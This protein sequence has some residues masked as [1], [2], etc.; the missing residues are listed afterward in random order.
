MKLKIFWSMLMAVA[1]T[2]GIIAVDPGVSSSIAFAQ[3]PKPTPPKSKAPTASASSSFSS[4]ERGLGMEYQISV[5]SNPETDRHVPASA[6]N[7]TNRQTLVVWHRHDSSFYYIEGRLLDARGKPIGSLP[8]T[9]VSGGTPV[10][11]PAVAYNATFNQYLVVWMRNTL[12]DGKTYA[13]WGKVLS[14]SLTEVRPEYAIFNPTT[15]YSAW[16]PRVA[17]NS[18]KNEYMVVWNAFNTT[19]WPTMFPESIAQASL[20]ENG[21]VIPNPMTIIYNTPDKLIYPQQVDIVFANNGGTN[22]WGQYMWV[23]KQVKLGT[24]DYDIWAANI[25]AGLGGYIQGL[26]PWKVD[27]SSSDQSN[28]RIATNG[29]NDF[30]V[31]WQERSPNSPN[32]WDI[33]GRE[34]NHIGTFFGDLHIIAGYGSTDETNPFVVGWAGTTPRY[35]VGYQRQS[36]TGQGIWLA[37][38]NNGANAWHI[39]PYI[40]WMDYFAAADYGF[41]SNT[42]PTGVVA[43]PHVQMAYEGVSNTPGDHTHIYSRN[44]TPF[45]LYLPLILK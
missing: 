16:S 41:W 27:D 4:Q 43:G 10:Y 30:M 6:Y 3:G 34:M 8:T 44:W 20:Y 38:Y 17:W 14:A 29:N 45:L 24:A 9:I 18:N 26:P 37:Y 23:W 32:D 31:V 28:P 11:Q 12:V 40:F 39:P 36:D 35:A 42:Y 13:I 5:P 25:D 19:S 1:F 21:D 7:S 22:N 15:N 33:R 2:L